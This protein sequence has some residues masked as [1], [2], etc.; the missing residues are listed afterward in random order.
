MFVTM[1]YHLHS[2]N[3]VGVKYIETYV[4]KPKAAH[5]KILGFVPVFFIEISTKHVTPT[6]LTMDAKSSLLQTWHTLRCL[7][8]ILS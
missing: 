5:S 2:F 1:P 6:E 3:S 7:N 8:F 4:L